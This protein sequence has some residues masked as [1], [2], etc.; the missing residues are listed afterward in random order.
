MVGDDFA[1]VV[2]WYD[3]EFGYATKLTDLALHIGS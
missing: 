3:N 1:K 2:S